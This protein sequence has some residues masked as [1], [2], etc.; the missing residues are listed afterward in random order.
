MPREDFERNLN[1]VQDDVVK[2][3]SMVEKAVFKSIDCLKNRDIEGS[4]QVIDEDDVIDDM[5]QSIE[6]RCID[7]IALEAPMASDLRG[8]ISALMVS[9]ELER[10]GDYAEGIA[11]ISIAMGNLPPLKPLIDIPRMADKAANM[12][13]QSL[14]SYVNKDAESAYEVVKSDDEVD[15]LYD[16]VY[17]ELLTYMMADP[18]TIQRATYLLWVAHDLERVADR[19][20]NI[21]ERVIYLVTG[22]PMEKF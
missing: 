20:T 16:Q 11:K 2:L 8:I 1:E 7:L 12:V 22:S 14:E 9:N 21:A 13:H 19:T 5:T 6:D 18:S 15:S 17:R 3:G 10:M 4:Q